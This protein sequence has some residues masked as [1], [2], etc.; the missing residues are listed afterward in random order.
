[1]HH[2]LLNQ[3]LATVAAPTFKEISLEETRTEERQQ[4]HQQTVRLELNHRY[5]LERLRVLALLNCAILTLQ[6]LLFYSGN[7]SEELLLNCI[8]FLSLIALVVQIIYVIAASQLHKCCT[9]LTLLL[10]VL[11]PNNLTP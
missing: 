9:W 6:A 8:S 10:L 7:P 3:S 11:H 5:E 1:M 2:N 4:L